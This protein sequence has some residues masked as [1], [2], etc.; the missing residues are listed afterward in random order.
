MNA[1]V[2]VEGATSADK[3]KLSVALMMLLG[4]AAGFHFWSEYSLLLRV[5]GLLAV[6]AVAGVL[7]FQTAPGR[8]VADFAIES[9]T[10]VRKVVWPTRQETMQTTLV[11]LGM[12]LVMGLVMWIVDW[13][14]L[15]IVRGVTG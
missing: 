1:K 14:L 9:R 4:A 2:E 7:A 10:E 12:V 13:A 8:A 3:A 15:G 11:V 6:V 5:I